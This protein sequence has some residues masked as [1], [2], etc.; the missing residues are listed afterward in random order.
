VT[1]AAKPHEGDHEQRALRLLRPPALLSDATYERHIAHKGG[2][3]LHAFE[4][5]L[6]TANTEK[7][8]WVVGGGWGWV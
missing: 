5:V 4:A 6:R 8:W 1:L 2:V 3:N 7:V